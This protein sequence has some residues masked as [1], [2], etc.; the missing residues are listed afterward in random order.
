VLTCEQKVFFNELWMQ[1]MQSVKHTQMH[2]RSPLESDIP[3]LLGQN[4][5]IK[6]RDSQ[7][8][9]SA[10]IHSSIRTYQLSKKNQAYQSGEFVE[11]LTENA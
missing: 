4:H 10:L 6:E 1:N 2:K 5:T 9:D 11:K 7:I 3:E 8:K